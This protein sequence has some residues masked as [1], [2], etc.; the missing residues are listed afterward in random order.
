MTARRL[1]FTVDS[2]LLRE[3]GERLVG[4]PHIALAELVKNS[5]DADASQVLIRF[6]PGKIEVID[7]GHGMSP[8]DFEDKWLRIGSTHKE[9]EVYS[10]TLHRPLTG[11]KGVGR[12]A[13]QL[14]ANHLE[15]RSVSKSLK[16]LELVADVDWAEAV[17]AGE[18]TKAPVIVDEIKPESRFAKDSPIGT[19]LILT[20]L[21]HSWGRENLRNSRESYGRFSRLSR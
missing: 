3:L 19:K 8:E 10:P 15:I 16:T 18:L 13:V 14:I 5:Y 9:R 1:T 21:N 17:Q 11:S 20:Q 12:L 4:R 6:M 7:D 2:R